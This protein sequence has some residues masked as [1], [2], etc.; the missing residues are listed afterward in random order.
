MAEDRE[1]P[2]ALVDAVEAGAAPAPS[3]EPNWAA[4]PRRS[5]SG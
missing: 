4:E 1:A 2:A 3:A 5:S